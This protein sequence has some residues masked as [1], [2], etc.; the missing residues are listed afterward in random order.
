MGGCFIR[1]YSKYFEIWRAY[2]PDDQQMKQ[3]HAPPCEEMKVWNQ[4]FKSSVLLLVL[5]LFPSKLGSY[6]SLLLLQSVYNVK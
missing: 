4:T 1:A 5:A 2:S 6:H 3:Y